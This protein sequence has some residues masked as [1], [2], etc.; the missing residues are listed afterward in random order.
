MKDVLMIPLQY[1]G[2]ENWYFFSYV[3]PY[4]KPQVAYRTASLRHWGLKLTTYFLTYQQQLELK[5]EYEDELRQIKNNPSLF[6]KNY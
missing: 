5:R 2:S 6:R 3:N 4:T 1:N